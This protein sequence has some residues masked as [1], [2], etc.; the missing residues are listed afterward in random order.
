[1]RRISIIGQMIIPISRE[2]IA[3]IVVGK[4]KCIQEMSLH[5]LSKPLVQRKIFRLYFR[6]LITIK[7]RQKL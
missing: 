5:E 1:M 2:M 6:A 4:K 7:S 3:R